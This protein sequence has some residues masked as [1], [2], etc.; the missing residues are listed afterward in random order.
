M[1]DVKGCF[2]FRDE[3]DGCLTSKYLEHQT[4][5]P[6]SECSK[7]K[8]GDKSGIFDPFIGE[9]TTCW[10]EDGGDHIADLSIT[11]RGGVYDL[12]WRNISGS[13]WEYGGTAMLF[14]EKLVGS[15]WKT[16]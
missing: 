15:Y 1:S 3:G 13:D 12:E 14:E 9:F 7:R 5:E 11:K 6:Y 8:P 4:A 2:V 16:K 10:L